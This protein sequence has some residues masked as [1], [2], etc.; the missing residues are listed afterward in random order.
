MAFLD[1]IPG[2]QYLAPA[3]L[4]GV[5]L[6]VCQLAAFSLGLLGTILFWVAILLLIAWALALFGII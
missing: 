4:I 5:V 2:R 3:I 1:T 6:L